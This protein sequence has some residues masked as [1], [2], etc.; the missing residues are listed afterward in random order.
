MAVS[1]FAPRPTAPLSLPTTATKKRDR[2]AGLDVARS[3]A[4]L[5]MFVA[6]YAY[7]IQGEDGIASSLSRFTDGRAMPLFVILGGVGI[8]LLTAR[9]THPDRALLGRAAVLFVAGLLLEART[10]VL[11]ILHFYALFF[12]LG[13]V[14]RRLPGWALLALAGVST[15]IGSAITL[16]D[17]E[18]ATVRDTLADERTTFGIVSIVERPL[19]LLTDL[20]A[21]GGYPLFPTLA[22]VTVGMWL[23]RQRLGATAWQVGLIC[24]GAALFAIGYGSS[25]VV[26]DARDDL[27]QLDADAN[28]ARIDPS[29]VDRI[30]AEFEIAPEDLVGRAEAALA[31][32]AS[33]DELDAQMTEAAIDPGD[34]LNVFDGSGHSH[35]PAWVVGATGFALA[36]IGL[37]LALTRLVP[38]LFAPL[39]AAGRM[40]LTF[41]VGHLIVLIRIQDT[42]PGDRSPAV[43][44]GIVAASFAAFVALATAWLR[45]VP[46]GPLEALLRLA[47]GGFGGFDSW[48]Q[49]GRVNP[50]VAPEPQVGH[51]PTMSWPAPTA[52]PPAAA[53]MGQPGGWPVAPPTRPPE[54]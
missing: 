31:D 2:L 27:V 38:A 16:A 51:P 25:W 45:F 10:N 13:M 35:Q 33:A 36:V 54:H 52:G 39:A 37:A 17:P 12:V 26:E 22:F 43:T 21:T 23:G 47:G 14:L 20:V 7:S 3:V 28:R 19:V 50:V 4:I 46:Y 40:A 48:T 9:A 53:P 15:A 6:H 1:S 34:A 11:V 24:A 41:Y 5:G 8:T 49:R 44:L 18:W 29:A 42:W 30:A 32:G